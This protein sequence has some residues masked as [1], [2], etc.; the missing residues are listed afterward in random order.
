MKRVLVVDDE[1]T[2]RSLVSLSL[3]GPE[4]KVDAFSDGRDAL[5][6]LSGD[7]PDLILLDVGLPGM[8]GGE[9]LKRLRADDR[10]AR[11][12]VVMLTGLEPPEG[13]KPDGVILKPF[14]PDSLRS[15]IQAWLF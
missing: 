14:T 6:S 10:T 4:C 7:Q 3:E 11:I 9:V 1:Q 2:V 15:S 13:S 12:P 5:E 8:S